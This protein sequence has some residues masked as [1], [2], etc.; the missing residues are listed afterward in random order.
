V[1]TVFKNG[2]SIKLWNCNIKEHEA[3][4]HGLNHF[5]QIMPISK[6]LFNPNLKSKRAREKLSL[7]NHMSRIGFSIS[8][9][10]NWIRNSIGEPFRRCLYITIVT[11]GVLMGMVHV[12]DN[13]PTFHE[14]V[15]VLFHFHFS[16]FQ[17]I[18]T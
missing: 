3:S 5:Q 8:I 11:L 6:Q 18:E 7:A 13:F 10:L 4:K 1:S 16:K 12:I 15:W 9:S 17:Q 2:G 14:T